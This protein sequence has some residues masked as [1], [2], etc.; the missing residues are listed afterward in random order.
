MY[1]SLISNALSHYQFTVVPV[2]TSVYPDGQLTYT[3]NEGN[4]VTF[5][6]TT[7]G[8]PDPEITWM[9][10]GMAFNSSDQRVMIR[11]MPTIMEVMRDSDNET[12][13]E[14]TQT[15]TL[16]TTMD[17]DSGMYECV[18]M[19]D[20]GQDSSFFELIVQ[21]DYCCCSMVV[22]AIIQTAWSDLIK[23]IVCRLLC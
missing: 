21:G 23:K 4:S 15:L 16:N 19:N 8:I 11:S 12:V 1:L 6:C 13:F 9:R 20:V 17:S 18:A 5:E 22:V 10:N 3:V 7:T 2:V 14:V